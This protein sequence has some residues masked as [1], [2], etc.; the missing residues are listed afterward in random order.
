MA[1]YLSIILVSFLLI[2]GCEYV[3]NIASP[4][5]RESTSIQESP[6]PTT[7]DELVNRESNF[8]ES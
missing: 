5:A 6:T 4:T 7:T 2:A 3:D 1:R 8:D